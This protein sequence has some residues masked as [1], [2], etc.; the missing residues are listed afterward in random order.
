VNGPRTKDQTELA[1][2]TIKRVITAKVNFEAQ[3]WRE[4]E[5]NRR[6]DEAWKVFQADMKDGRL[7]LADVNDLNELGSG[8]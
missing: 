6:I 8:Q 1:W 2:S 3:V 4:K 7:Q 5:L